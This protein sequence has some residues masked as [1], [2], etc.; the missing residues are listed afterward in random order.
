[1]KQRNRQLILLTLLA[2]LALPFAVAHGA[3][4]GIEGKVTD[5]KGAIV[6]GATVTVTDLLT[7]QRVTTIT[8]QQGRYKIEG[9]TAGSYSLVVSQAGFTEARRDEVKVADGAVTTVDIKLEIA[10][11]EAAVTV[12]ATKANVDP[13]YQ[14]LRQQAKAAGEFG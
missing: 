10:A 11:V 2:T 13:A 3:G 12:T 8:D 14:Q 4:G 7:N 5:P 1:M 9:L 6:V